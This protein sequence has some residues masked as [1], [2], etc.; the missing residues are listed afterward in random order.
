M[1]EKKLDTPPVEHPA[2]IPRTPPYETR[3]KP[4]ERKAVNKSGRRNMRRQAEADVFP[5]NREMDFK[6]AR[7]NATWDDSIYDPS[8]LGEMDATRKKNEPII[9]RLDNQETERQRELSIMRLV[10]YYKS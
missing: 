2:L 5:W 3:E 4:S 7:A 6:A 8:T 9:E 10:L 1:R